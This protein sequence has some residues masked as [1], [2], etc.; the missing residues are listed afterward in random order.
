MEAAREGEESV[1]KYRG[2]KERIKRG[3]GEE[4]E[5]RKTGRKG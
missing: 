2:V 1:H 3:A 5:E 4:R